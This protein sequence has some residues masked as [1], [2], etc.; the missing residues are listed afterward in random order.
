MKTIIKKM[1]YSVYKR[2]GDMT[3][4]E[5]KE[6][7]YPLNFFINKSLKNIEREKKCSISV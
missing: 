4:E 6:C 2:L 5:I 7:K 3:E 1:K